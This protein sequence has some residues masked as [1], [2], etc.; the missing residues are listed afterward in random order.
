VQ[1]YPRSAQDRPLF[2]TTGPSS[3]D[4]GLGA[5]CGGSKAPGNVRA[6]A[7][8]GCRKSEGWIDWLECRGAAVQGGK[9]HRVL[10]M[11]PDHGANPNP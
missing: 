11:D 10:T 7:G 1:G 2:A 8:G 4:S 3:L 6:P 9:G 5:T